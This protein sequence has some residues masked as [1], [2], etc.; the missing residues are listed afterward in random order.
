MTRT[1]ELTNRLSSDTQVIQNAMTV[2][3]SMLARYIVQIVGSLAVMFGLSWKLT[4]VLLSVVPPVA[5][6]AVW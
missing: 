2:N 4:L 5:I 6:G 3:I 1:G